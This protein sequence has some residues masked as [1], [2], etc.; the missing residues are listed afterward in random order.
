MREVRKNFSGAGSSK[1]LWHIVDYQT[2]FEHAHR[3]G[4]GKFFLFLKLKA[5]TLLRWLFVQKD[6]GC[7]G[8]GTAL[9]LSFAAFCVG[10]DRVPENKNPQGGCRECSLLGR[11][12][13]LQ[14]G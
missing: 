14:R 9:R 7:C 2:I 13:V 3:R 12:L 8:G 4:P 5:V 6:G 10:L 1:G 11:P